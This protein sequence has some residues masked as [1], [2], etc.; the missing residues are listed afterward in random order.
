M[1]SQTHLVFRSLQKTIKDILS[2]LP[3]TTDYKLKQGLIDAHT[4]LSDYYYKFDASPY[5]LWAALLDPRVGYAGLEKCF[6]DDHSLLSELNSSKHQLYA[7]KSPKKKSFLSRLS[8][9]QQSSS[10]LKNELDIY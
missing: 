9:T 1:L 3:I 5:Y 10:A 2:D 6:E 7:P 8:T 4:K